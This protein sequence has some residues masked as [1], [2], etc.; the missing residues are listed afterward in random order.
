M[1]LDCFISV[2]LQVTDSTHFWRKFR[3][4]G[5]SEETP[6][7]GG[8]DQLLSESFDHAYGGLPTDLR[9]HA[10]S[11]FIAT[12]IIAHVRA[13]DCTQDAMMHAA[14]DAVEELEKRRR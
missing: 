4:S 9:T 2:S 6:D 7:I 1:N 3:G 5:Q 10:T 12:S 8:D 11:A 13:S 14:L